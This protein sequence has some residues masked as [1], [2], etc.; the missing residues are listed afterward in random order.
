MK[1]TEIVSDSYVKVG[2]REKIGYGFG[3]LASNLSF[4]LSPCSYCFFIP[5]FTASARY[6][7][8]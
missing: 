3:D 4:V 2:V 7:R 1:T 8:A 5:I 6:R